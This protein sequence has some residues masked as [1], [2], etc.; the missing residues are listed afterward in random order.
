MKKKLV[1]SI[2][3]VVLLGLGAPFTVFGA[4][5]GRSGGILKVGCQPTN[6]LDP[7]F[8]ASISDILLLE[9]VYHHL[10]FID[11]KNQAVPDLA[12]S[13]ESADGKT[14]VFHLKDGV[15][16]SDGRPVTSKDVVF[17]YNRL[18]DAKV[19]APTVKLYENVTAIE[20]VAP[21]TVK[22]TLARSNPEF[23]ADTGDYHACVIPD[24]TKDPAKERLGSGPYVVAAVFPE[25][26]IVLK[27]NPHF[28]MKDADGSALPYLEEIHL[29]FSPDMGGQVEALRGGELNFVG[30]LTTEFAATVEKDPN[31]KVLKNA[32]NMHWMIHMRSDQ[33]HVAADNRVRQAFKLATDHTAII[34]AVRPGLAAPGNGFSPVGPAYGEY[35]LNQPPATDIEKAKALLAEAGYAKGLKID[36]VAQ[37]Q[38]DVIP[39]ATVWKDQLA[40]IGVT[41]NIQVVPTDL[42]YGEG[43]NSWL[44]CDFGITD[45]GT[46]AT[47]VTYYNL[48]YTSDGPWNGAHWS[49]PEFDALAHQVDSE[50]DQAKRVQLYHQTQKI[51]IER[52]PVINAYFEMAV[53]GVSSKLEQVELA[54]D[55]ARTRFWNSYFKK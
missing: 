26:R 40:K 20:A 1:L 15:K 27:K 50:M 3:L 4:S 34:N 30:G 39:I 54:S 18:R 49:D 29:V 7:H 51:L 48:A 31:A 32:S 28:A 5:D 43:E 12:A 44:K 42:Y 11:A 45:W 13:W 35:Y 53:A 21:L 55:W 23:P 2:F 46:R 47:P 41:V 14:W 22:F 9:Q 24:G 16:F 37:N 8:S 52:G 6:N 33:G 17:S 19:G 36:L 38:L 10:T 25:D